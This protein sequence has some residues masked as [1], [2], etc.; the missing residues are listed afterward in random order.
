[1]NVSGMLV[2]GP[3][4]DIE[5]LVDFD[6]VSEEENVLHQTGEFPH[7]PQVFQCAGGLGRHGLLGG[8][9]GLLLRLALEARHLRVESWTRGW[10]RVQWMWANLLTRDRVCMLLRASNRTRMESQDNSR[11][12]ENGA[13]VGRAPLVRLAR[14]G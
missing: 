5:I 14:D 12:M 7:V 1:M 9:I 2:A 3:Y 11:K 4:L 8:R 10:E 13:F 6:G